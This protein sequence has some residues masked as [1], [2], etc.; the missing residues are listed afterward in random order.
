MHLFLLSKKLPDD[1]EN[2]R[3]ALEGLLEHLGFPTMT[4][5]EFARGPAGDA[6]LTAEVA[7]TH[8]TVILANALGEG[9]S[10]EEACGIRSANSLF[11]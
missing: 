11:R 7:L 8:F 9:R 3:N 4:S 2:L 6:V 5:E 1:S 10:F